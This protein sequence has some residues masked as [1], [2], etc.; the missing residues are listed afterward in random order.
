M[1]VRIVL[2]NQI[3][4]FAVKDRKDKPMKGK[5]TKELPSA[6]EDLLG[7]YE[8]SKRTFPWRNTDDPYRIWISEVMLQQTRTSRAADYYL[9]WMEL[10]PTLEDLARTPEEGVLK[11][12]EGL[13]YYGRAKNLLRAAR[14]LAEEGRDTLPS[15]LHALLSLPGVGAY[16]AAAVASIAFGLAVPA[17]D[18]NAK[19][20]FARLTDL[21]L[22][23]DR[24]EGEEILRNFMMEMMP[25]EKPGDF[26]Q[27]VMDLGATVC[28]SVTPSCPLCP[29]RKVCLSAERKTIPQRPV[30]SPREK[31]ASIEGQLWVLK[32]EGMVCL[33]RRPS[34]GL[35]ADFEEFPWSAPPLEERILPFSP[36][37][38]GSFSSLGKVRSSF[39][40]WRLTLDVLLFEGKAGED[41]A[42]SQA[43]WVEGRELE[44]LPLPGP[45]RK[46][47]ELLFGKGIISVR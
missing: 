16:T 29:L 9:R 38:P 21:E 30:F 5:I 7:W 36:P 42:P 45:S 41:F 27:A 28:L 46:A 15:E 20:V 25:P 3:F 33:R 12:W 10:F 34:K 39:T 23:V 1:L 14:L 47:R 24:A 35:W 26:N 6:G 40:R 32:N 44:T 17:L 37:A 31:S 22:P 13:G 43:R 8:G 2:Y 18:A 11:A 19:R 4:R